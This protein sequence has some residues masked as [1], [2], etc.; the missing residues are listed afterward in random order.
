M[1]R[2]FDITSSIEFEGIFLPRLATPLMLIVA[3]WVVYKLIICR[4][5]NNVDLLINVCNLKKRALP[6]CPCMREPMM[7]GKRIFQITNK[8]K[9]KDTPQNPSSNMNDVSRQS[10]MFNVISIQ[11]EEVCNTRRNIPA[12]RSTALDILIMKSVA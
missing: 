4:V 8:N 1:L 11:Y 2:S 3:L 7:T 6:F 10:Q 5:K 9:K 12:S